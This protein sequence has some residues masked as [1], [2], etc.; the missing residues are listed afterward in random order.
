[1][2]QLGVYLTVFQ[3][4][5]RLQ[6]PARTVRHLANKGELPGIKIGNQWRFREEAII[7]WL[8]Q[9]EGFPVSPQSQTRAERKSS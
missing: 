9:R 6:M 8:R 4:S 1:M 2:L 7:E 5:R 3:I